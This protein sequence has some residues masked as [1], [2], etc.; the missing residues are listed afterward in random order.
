MRMRRLGIPNLLEPPLNGVL[1]SLACIDE[2]IPAGECF[3]QVMTHYAIQSTT[4]GEAEITVDGR[5]L[6]HRPGRL[7]AIAPGVELRE[8]A[9]KPWRVRYVM[10]DG[11]WCAPLGEALQAT[12]GAVM[13]DRPPAPW[14]SALDTVVD[15]GIDG[16]PGSPWRIAGALA[17]LLGGLA[18]GQ[19]HAGD[20]LAELGR[21]ID[22]APE[23]SW[24]V[25]GLARTLRLAPRTL[26]ARFNACTG[27]GPVR[28]V[29]QRR[30]AHATLMLQRGMAVK[31]VAERLGFANQFHFS[32]AYKRCCGRAPSAAWS[33]VR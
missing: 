5:P 30:M 33:Q 24:S 7:F 32:R 29:L 22:A 13:L 6:T 14:L 26:Q 18:V 16:G 9:I 31:E 8:R 11:S 15:A 27:E 20:L 28:W 25:A 10:L 4:Q 2:L 17:I 21:V 12:G 19:P 23:R 1:G 3:A